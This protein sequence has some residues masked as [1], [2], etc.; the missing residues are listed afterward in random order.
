[1]ST[2]TMEASPE[3]RLDLEG[4]EK[5]PFSRLVGVELRKSYNTRA[6]FWLLAII[7]FFVV[8]TEGIVLAVTVVQDQAMS[9]DD[10]VGAAAFVT[11]ILLPILGIMLVTAEWGQRT[12]M[13]TFALEPRRPL[14]IFA[15]MAVGIILTLG[16]IV[17]A[18]AVG[19]VA[20]LL[21]AAFQGQGPDWQFG[22]VG[23]S[24]FVVTQIMSMLGGF[25][26]AALFLNTPA[27]IVVFFVYK[28]VLPG[29]L[30]LGSELVG[31]IDKI[32]PWIDFQAAQNPL[33]NG[34]EFSGN[35]PGQLIVSA[36]IWLVLP[37]ALGIRRV[38]RAEVK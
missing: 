4:I 1:M 3:P 30:A 29:L 35:E 19:V 15:K 36:L 5:V 16:T 23:A 33:F 32:A 22:F 18:V 21:Y 38:L 25:A 6:G 9:L 27:S 28:Y 34:W 14:V 17:A 20:N 13:V 37:L 31:F 12:A 24:G 8:L 7:G 26:I 2:Q 11:S 10:F